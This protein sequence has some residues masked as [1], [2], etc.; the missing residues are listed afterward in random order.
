[1]TEN[2][3]EKSYRIIIKL[4]SDYYHAFI[5]VDADEYNFSLTKQEIID[6]LKLKKVTF[7][8]NPNVIEQVIANPENVEHLEIATGIIHEHGLDSKL[9]YKI[10]T[11]QDLKP[12]ENADGTVDFKNMNFAQ[13][14]NKGDI[15]VEKTP[16]IVG[17]NGTTVTGMN[18]KARDGKILNFKFG[19]NVA[20]SEDEMS[21]HSTVDGTLKLEG[22]KVSVVEILEIFTDV[23]VKTGNISFTGKVIIRGNVTNGFKVETPD[24]I[25]INGV[26]ESADIIAGGNILINGGVQGNDNSLIKSNGDIK[27]NYFNN[28]KVIANG[29]IHADSIM[30]SEII[31]DETINV[32]GKKGLIMGGSC[33]A[34]H[35]IIAKT[36]GSEMGTITKFQLGITNEIMNNFQ[37]LAV[38]IKDY[39]DNISK[40]KKAFDILKK[41]KTIK[42]DDQKISDLFTNTQSSLI[43]YT[44]KLKVT[45]NE[46]KEV[47]EL[48]EKLKDVYLKADTIYPG[49]RVKIGNSHYNV[50]NDLIRTKITKAH[51]EVILKDY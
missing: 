10:D 20:L 19:K 44:D 7:G 26:V 24:D 18:I 15:L 49:V 37:E 50:K 51:G 36:V 48:I 9:I 21:I 22:I 29:S 4:S 16:I 41:Q 40:L 8:I 1:M 42:P 12:S 28:C 11:N 45:M 35:Y 38:K 17:K 23:G 14:V 6:E 13:S 32:T 2:V 47:N 34:R 39:K 3:I 27:S 46:F 43:D 33:T 5:T 25:E 30:H 31:C